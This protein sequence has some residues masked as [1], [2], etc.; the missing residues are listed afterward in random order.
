MKIPTIAAACLFSASFSHASPVHNY[1]EMGLGASKLFS[2]NSE[3]NDSLSDFS[4]SPSL[5]ILTGSRLNQ[6]RTLWFELGYSHNG[7]MKYRDTKLNS[8]SLFTGIKLSSDPV[9]NTSTFLRGGMGKTWSESK[10]IG[11]EVDKNQTTHY[12]AGAG[13]NFRLDLKTSLAIELQQINDGSSDEA[14]NGLF[15]SFNQFI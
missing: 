11:E 14:I 3:T 1:F 15:L 6:S 10:T 7:E 12:Y 5:K 9:A 13:I 2:F 4:I 8:Q